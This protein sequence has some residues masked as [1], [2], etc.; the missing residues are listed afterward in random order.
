MIF[1]PHLLRPTLDRQYLGEFTSRSLQ[2]AHT[3][4]LA[5]EAL[6][7][8]SAIE[9]QSESALHRQLAE[10]YYANAVLDLRAYLTKNDTESAEVIALQA[11]MLLCIFEVRVDRV[12]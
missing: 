9:L 10:S 5:M 6:L 8:C 2:I 11:A 7:A 4:P 12:I 1:L 3:I